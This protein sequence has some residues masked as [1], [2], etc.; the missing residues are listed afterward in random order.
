MMP[1]GLRKYFILHSRKR[2][3]TRKIT[4][5]LQTIEAF[6][7]VPD[8]PYIAVSG[9]KDSSVL[10]AL[11]R[12]V[13]P[14]LDAVHLDYHTAYPETDA[15]FDTYTN[16]T[17]IDLYDKLEGFARNGVHDNP[18]EDQKWM[19]DS[20]WDGF[21]YGLRGEEASGRRRLASTRGEIF[22]NTRG[23]WICQPLTSFTYD[24][25]WAYIVSEGLTYNALYDGMWD[26]PKD[27]QRVATYGM[28]K[29]LNYGPAA[30]LKMTHPELFNHLI[31]HTDGFKEYI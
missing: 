18:K 1:A 17:R 27:S 29:V 2:H 13:K 16:L 9:G 7:K 14:P 15:I 12:R 4:N 10:L 5:A 26:R 6:L 23:E 20:K 30:Y 28:N 21:F 22:Q 19:A 3:Y 25:I 24:D 8:N 11:C 31:Q